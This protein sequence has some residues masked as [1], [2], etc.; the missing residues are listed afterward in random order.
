MSWPT[1]PDKK[2]LPPGAIDPDEYD[3]NNPEH[4]PFLRRKYKSLDQGQSKRRQFVYDLIAKSRVG[5]TKYDVHKVAVAKYGSRFTMSM[6]IAYLDG[7][8]HL[9]MIVNVGR[10]SKRAV[11]YMQGP[12]PFDAKALWDLQAKRHKKKHETAKAKRR[13]EMA[14][15]PRPPVPWEPYSN[16]VDTKKLW[17]RKR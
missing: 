15:R 3:P 2:Y 11:V 5:L 7:M 12:Q 4:N 6:V 8:Q 9:K 14:A 17:K 1:K 10:N 13:A 16:P